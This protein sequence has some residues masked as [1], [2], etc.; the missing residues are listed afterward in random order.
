MDRGKHLAASFSKTQIDRL[1]DRLRHG[2]LAESDLR[3]LDDYRRSFGQVYETV[4]QILREQLRLEPTG[5]SAKSTAS[6]TEKL[7][8]E[9]IRLAQVQD[10]AGCRV[11]VT[12][13]R[14]QDR[15]VASLRV[16]FPTASIV[17]RR[18]NPSY[19]YRAVHVIVQISGRLVEVQVR[20]SL[21]HLWAELSEKLSDVVDPAIKYGGGAE[22]IRAM[23]T[24]GSQAIESLEG[25][26]T[27][28]AGMPEQE[29]PERQ[30]V[31]QSLADSKAALG[32]LLSE[33]IVWVENVRRR[34]P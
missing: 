29:A 34:Q 9:S 20:S 6:L 27:E 18:R 31:T 3:L 33:V 24:S 23:L 11:V 19:G 32:K 5:R 1:G 7:R 22:W 17:D 8:R 16:L 12:S 2:T 4:V 25:W 26:E 30:H 15:V 21:Q 14:E 28:L 13:V 10:I